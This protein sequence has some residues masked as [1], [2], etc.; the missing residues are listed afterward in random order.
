MRESRGRSP[1]KV[2]PEQSPA[3]APGVSWEIFRFFWPCARC[4]VRHSF[5][6]IRH[7]L[8]GDASPK[9]ILA[10]AGEAQQPAHTC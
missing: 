7:R 1:L 6:L 5:D 3:T 2:M 8:C 9:F 4:L 10:G